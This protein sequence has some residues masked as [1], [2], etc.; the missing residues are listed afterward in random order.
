M[1]KDIQSESIDNVEK[2]SGGDVEV[3]RA[4]AIKIDNL[5][6]AKIKEVA[7]KGLESAVGSKKSDS[8]SMKGE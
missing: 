3:A 4:A 5:A 1:G 7:L 2:I 6:K 8:A